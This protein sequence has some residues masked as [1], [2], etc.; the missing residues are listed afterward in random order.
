MSKPYKMMFQ[1]GAVL[2]NTIPKAFGAVSSLVGQT[3]TKLSNL[4]KNT[5]NPFAATTKNIAELEIAME[6]AKSKEQQLQSAFDKLSSRSTNLRKE[7]MRQEAATQNLALKVKSTDNPTRQQIKNLADSEIKAHKL[8]FR[9]GELQQQLL[10]TNSEIK[11]QAREVS[12]LGDK[13]NNSSKKIQFNKVVLEQ[14]DKVN[15]ALQNAANATMLARTTVGMASFMLDP[16]KQAMKFETVMSEVRK[17]VHFDTPMQFQE[18]SNQLKEMST[19]VPVAVDG[20]AHI[21]AAAAQA[22]IHREDLLAFTEDAAHMATAW[23]ISAEQSGDMLAKWRSAFKLTQP[24]VVKL[25]DQIHLLSDNTAATGSEIGDVV[26]RIGSLGKVAGVSTQSVAALAATSI[27]AGVKSE[28]AATGIKKM[29]LTLSSGTSATKNQAKAFNAL[30]IDVVKLGKNMQKNGVES[31]LDVLA[32]IK[33]LS[34]EKQAPILKQIFGEES[35]APIAGIMDNLDQVKHNLSL[36]GDEAKYSGLMVK[37]FGIRSATTENAVQLFHNNLAA[38]AI[39]IGNTFLP[40]INQSISEINQLLNGSIAPFISAHLEAIKTLGEFALGVGAVVVAVAGAKAAFSALN[41]I[42]GIGTGALKIL[43]KTLLWFIPQQTRAAL[44]TKLMAFWQG[45]VNTVMKA[46][47]I[48]RIVT[49]IIALGGAI[50]WVCTHCEEFTGWLGKAWEMIKKVFGWV[51]KL[52]DAIGS[53]FDGNDGT[54]KLDV[55]YEVK[56]NSRFASNVEALATGQKEK[57]WSKPN[58][59]VNSNPTVIIQGNADDAS[60]KRGMS[61]AHDKAIGDMQTQL[62]PARATY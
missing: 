2:Q 22:G 29:L 3:Q 37:E 57:N 56:N 33:Q 10:K 35:I 62:Y 32:K 23:S 26:T 16:I 5:Q 58:M 1:I 47:P 11:T 60:I 18:M 54:K 28:I 27:G 8:S 59:T 4:A 55:E 46:N 61:Q 50:Y 38:I 49:G 42:W 9:L 20:L 14:R 21:T 19:R 17:L 36:V 13:Y 51:M 12:N 39:T 43:G 41:A 44:A 31:M 40:A 25:A 45:I 53:L 30:G 6:Q 48:I 7:L 15:A 52:K 34:P 24:E